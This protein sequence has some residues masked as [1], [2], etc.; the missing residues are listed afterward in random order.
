M[1]GGAWGVVPRHLIDPWY[2]AIF[3]RRSV[4][5]YDGRPVGREAIGEI[6]ELLDGFSPLCEGARAVLLEE[7]AQEILSGTVGSIGKIQGAG[8]VVVFIADKSHP[9]WQAAAGYLGEGIILHAT[10]LGL[11]T[12]WVAG[13]Y[14]RSEARR[15]IALSVSESIVAVTPLG[16]PAAAES[17]GAQVI[18]A[19]AGSH[20]RK[21]LETLTR[22]V[23]ADQWR[24]GCREAL[25]AARLAPSAANRQPWQFGVMPDRVVVRASGPDLMPVV[26]NRLDCGIVM[27][28][29]EVG[30]RAHGLEGSWTFL[31]R[32]LVAE[33]VFE[34]AGDPD[35]QAR[36]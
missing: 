7:G 23:A 15:R 27:L 21:P 10:S 5:A 35:H 18:R 13:T 28:H 36:T 34:P 31:Q 24:L 4:R 11:G 19:V 26:P 22:G 9:Q 30:A 33:Y 20:K 29:L 6:R 8:A 2:R 16:R 32:P 3:V 25:E 17:A 1:G 14:K 12:C